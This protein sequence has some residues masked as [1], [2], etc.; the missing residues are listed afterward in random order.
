MPENVALKVHFHPSLTRL[1]SYEHLLT[2][3]I[4]RYLNLFTNPSLI[5]VSITV[6]TFD[7]CR[8]HVCKNSL[9]ARSWQMADSAA[10]G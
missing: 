1:K 2:E 5:K 4:Y 3:N 6:D 9:D 10:F 7:I 8:S